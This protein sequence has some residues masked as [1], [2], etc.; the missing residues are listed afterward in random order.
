MRSVD[1]KI[2]VKE[3]IDFEGDKNEN[4]A[5]DIYDFLTY[6]KIKEN[7]FNH[8][9]NELSSEVYIE[10][11]DFLENEDIKSIIESLTNLFADIGNEY[12]IN[13]DRKEVVEKIEFKLDEIRNQF[14][15]YP[16]ND[17]L[18]IL[19]LEK[20]A[21]MIRKKI[22][23]EV[24]AE[25]F[26]AHTIIFVS[27]NTFNFLTEDY[28]KKKYYNNKTHAR[29]PKYPSRDEILINWNL[30]KMGLVQFI[31]KKDL[32]EE[33][34]ISEEN[35]RGII[36]TDCVNWNKGVSKLVNL[37]NKKN[38]YVLKQI[39]NFCFVKN[40][41]SQITQNF[42]QVAKSR[43]DGDFLSIINIQ[44]KS[45]RKSLNSAIK[46]KNKLLAFIKK[47]N[48][49]P[50]KCTSNVVLSSNTLTSS[51]PVILFLEG[52]MDIWNDYYQKCIDYEIPYLISIQ[53]RNLLNSCFT[54]E[55]RNQV[56]E[57]IKMQHSSIR[58]PDSFGEQWRSLVDSERDEILQFLNL[59]IVDII[60]IHNRQDYCFDAASRIILP[61]LIHDSNIAKQEIINLLKIRKEQIITW[62]S[63]YSRGSIVSFDY[64]DIGSQYYPIKPP[65]IFETNH[66]KLNKVYLVSYLF[67]N[68]F[69][70]GQ[71]NFNKLLYEELDNNFRRNENNWEE[72]NNKIMEIKPISIDKTDYEFEESIQR[73]I[74]VDQFEIEFDFKGKLIK[75]IFNEYSKFLIKDFRGFETE[76]IDGI[77]GREGIEVLPLDELL[78]DLGMPEFNL[79]NEEVIRKSKELRNKYLSEDLLSIES[80]VWKILLKNKA[81]KVGENT[82]YDELNKKCSLMGFDMV[83][84]DTFKNAWINLDS[85]SNRT[86]YKHLKV[87]C[88][89]LGL[90]R[91]YFSFL[92]VYCKTEANKTR[93]STV[94][95]T[96]LVT[97]ILLPHIE[98]D[99]VD[100]AFDTTENQKDSLLLMGIAQDEIDD[101][102]IFYLEKTK[103]IIANK[104]KKLKTITKL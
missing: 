50:V 88:D 34:I 64:R 85:A 42:L 21:L 69:Y 9:N 60:K 12:E 5:N 101:K 92:K 14:Q 75:R 98:K 36:V 33:F 18:K 23:I 19:M 61:K 96:E 63:A 31:S 89:Y 82:L 76:D 24:L 22:I 95:H 10:V 77:I 25:K 32:L 48:P 93:Q 57:A 55:I 74:D 40:E 29:N 84:F 94:F 47:R 39:K 8:N 91:D 51:S 28:A 26:D 16:T 103:K 17:E 80:R 81:N 3:F 79:E 99:N 49:N 90:E 11:D 78:S 73:E 100:S 59:I 30:K 67:E 66:L 6:L 27:T 104:T 7:H 62:S 102:L 13:L 38:D 46:R 87:L 72:L 68:K 65:N 41:S 83:S 37:K 56:I 71:Y 70:Y 52:K 53:F 1:V 86:S 58:L 15:Q 4:Y 45:H 44:C 54:L 43:N 20:I 97:D 2:F 35:S